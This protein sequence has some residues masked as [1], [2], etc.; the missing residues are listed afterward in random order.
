MIRFPLPRQGIESVPRSQGQGL[1]RP[2]CRFVF[3][4]GKPL[5]Y[6]DNRTLSHKSA[7]GKP[8][9]LFV[10][11]DRRSR[12]NAKNR[13]AGWLGRNRL[14]LPLGITSCGSADKVALVY[15]N[16][17]E[18]GSKCRRRG[19]RLCRRYCRCA[20][21]H[22]S[23][24]SCC[25]SVF[26]ITDGRININKPAVHS[27]VLSNPVRRLV[28]NLKAGKDPSPVCAPVRDDRGRTVP[29][30]GA[31][32]LIGPLIGRYPTCGTPGTA[33]PAA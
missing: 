22:S 28:R 29:F 15:Q 21:T 9:A 5:P 12:S 20:Y 27:P 11:S 3:G 33:S 1:F 32:A 30:V 23:R 7:H 19:S 6:K 13:S 17:K 14:Q 8:C 4:R 31:D 18:N 24:R 2:P 25:R 16:I 26:I 10:S